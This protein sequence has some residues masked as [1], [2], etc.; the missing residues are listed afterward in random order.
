MS[1]ETGSPSP[2]QEADTQE[3][4]RQPEVPAHVTAEQVAV[5]RPYPLPDGRD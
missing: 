2:N 5:R 3:A 1:P 4:I